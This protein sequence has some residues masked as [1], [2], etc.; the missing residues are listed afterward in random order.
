MRF[1]LRQIITAVA[2]LTACHC[3]NAGEIP[4]RVIS[5]NV[6]TDQLAMLLAKPG[7]LYSLSFLA[8]DPKSSVMHE[9][10]KAYRINRG[11]AE[12]IYLMNPDLILAGTFTTRSTVA[13]L[14]D[15]GFRVE[16]F[17]PETTI[18]EVK[19]N[20]KRLGSLL[21]TSETA[22]RIVGEM[23]E[24]LARLKLPKGRMPLAAFYYSNS[25][26][27]GAGTIISDIARHA[28]LRNLG[29]EKGLYG[30]AYLSL[31]QLILSKPDLI[32]ANETRE[33]KPALAQQNFQHP[34]YRQLLSSVK[35]AHIDGRITACGGPF[36]I[37]AIEQLNA[38][39]LQITAPDR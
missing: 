10:A 18:D 9:E 24:R 4:Q 23:D 33:E 29:E 26:T 8:S 6:C 1:S 27:S 25:Y 3:A 22:D 19:H 39:A 11:R 17:A 21:G 12:E 7:Q 13:M 2:S 32:V 20:I 30:T 16:E 31:E 34:A 15:L 35:K 5:L 28:G 14:R 38:D 37:D 36:T